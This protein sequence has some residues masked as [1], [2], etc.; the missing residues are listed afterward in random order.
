V[1]SSSALSR[2]KSFLVNGE[3]LFAGT[4]RDGVFCSTD[5]GGNWVPANSG[6][7]NSSVNCLEYNGNALFAGS[8]GTAFRSGDG[9]VDWIRASTGLATP[10]ITCLVSSGT[11][12]YA[13]TYSGVY[14]ST[15]S[16]E[17]W[18][19]SNTG[20][21]DTSVDALGVSGTSVFVSTTGSGGAGDGN[22]HRSVDSGRTWNRL[23]LGTDNVVNCFA[24]VGA[25]IF[26]GTWGKGIFH[27]TDDG[28]TWTP[29]GGSGIIESFAF[30]GTKLYAGTERGGIFRSTDKGTTWDSFTIGLT[31][32][33]VRS[34]IFWEPYLIAACWQDGV[35]VGVD[36]ESG[37][38]GWTIAN[39]GFPG[40][41]VGSLA[42]CGTDIFAGTR[43]E[44]VWRRPLSEM[45]TSVHPSSDELAQDFSL[46]QNYPNP[47]NPSTIIRYG[48]PKRSH[49]TLT[50]LNMLG[51]H[52]TTL[53]QG[54]QEAGY[55]E[56]KFEGSGLASGCYLCRMRAGPYTETKRLL[57]LR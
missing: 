11:I 1:G 31:D 25:D 4:F 53:S 47:F 15:D 51:Q 42:V 52:V 24:V 41:Y 22:L 35:F 49:V 34:L 7:T 39:A 37:L 19:S 56:V 17:H 43:Y 48:L 12:L 3:Y 44:G 40:V 5:D 30:A 6:L 8:D 38:T 23:Y 9:G 21:T 29:A 16:G 46:D 36:V 54:E 55:H 2:I 20:L 45:I 14:R 57:L 10:Y 27:S 26:A 13:G 18:Y 33:G 28:T 32:M 50:V